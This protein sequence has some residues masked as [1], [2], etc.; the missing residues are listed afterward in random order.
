MNASASDSMRDRFHAVASDLLRS[1]PSAVV[2]L[3]A[4]GSSR[5]PADL[6]A[7]VGHRIIDVGIREQAMIGVAAGFALEGMRPIVMSYTPFLVERPFEQIK[8][9]LTHQGVAATLVSIGASWDASTEGRTHQAPEDVALMSTLPGWSVHVPGSADEAEIALRAAHAD[10]GS[11][12]IRLSDD[13]NA[14]RY[15]REVGRISTLRRGTHDAP[16]VL[17]VGPIADAVLEAVGES[18]YTVLYT[19][20]PKPLDRRGLRAATLGTDLVLIEPYLEGTSVHEVSA[21][22]DRPMRIRSIGVTDPE[23]ETY[24]TR[25]ELQAAH[26]LDADGIR[27]RLDLLLVRQPA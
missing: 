10:A 21:A 2:V 20:V 18:D 14:D 25:T 26:G 27:R 12:Y 9:S 5:F 1:D 8:I 16:T 11:H 24:G 22:F 15:E 23:I 6:R 4:I 17:A 3:A 7:E 13:A 19:S